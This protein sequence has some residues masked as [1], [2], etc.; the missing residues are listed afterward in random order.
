MTYRFKQ[1]LRTEL[2]RLGAMAQHATFQPF[3]AST[4]D[5]ASLFRR[6]KQQQK[7][8]TKRTLRFLTLL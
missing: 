3:F 1:L 7:I 4:R 6:D 5:Y 8:K 2:D